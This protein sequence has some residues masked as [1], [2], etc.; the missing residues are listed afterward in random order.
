MKIP[1]MKAWY[2]AHNGGVEMSREEFVYKN[3][4]W[5]FEIALQWSGIAGRLACSLQR[6]VRLVI[7]Q[8]PSCIDTGA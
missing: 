4:V 3:R 8:S 7:L 2:V 1:L 6:Q 5:P